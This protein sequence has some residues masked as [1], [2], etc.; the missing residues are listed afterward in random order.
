MKNNPSIKIEIKSHTDSGALDNYNLNLSERRANSVLN[1]IISKG[2]N[3]N[4][5]SGKGYG[6]TQLIN[7]CSNGVKCTEAEH[8]MNRRTEFVIIDE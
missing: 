1:H 8:Q 5:L 3:S 2:I 7:K 6:A 4:R